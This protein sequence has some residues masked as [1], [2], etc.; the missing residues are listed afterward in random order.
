MVFNNNEGA[1]KKYDNFMLF[2]Y[3]NSVIIKNIN[4]NLHRL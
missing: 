3:I 2:Y 1:V 4:P